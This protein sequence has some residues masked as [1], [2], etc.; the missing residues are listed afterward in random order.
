MTNFIY[1]LY[2][3][4]SKFNLL[5][6]NRITLNGA[7]SLRFLD[8]LWIHLNFI[9]MKIRN[10]LDL[11]FLYYFRIILALLFI[12]FLYSLLSLFLY[13]ITNYFLTQY[14]YKDLILFRDFKLA[15]ILRFMIFKITLNII[16]FLLLLLLEY[17]DLIIIYNRSIRQRY[18]LFI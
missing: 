9:I 11:W 5:F 1:N 7:I 6:F 17:I 12:F 4:F 14:V 10:S 13:H 8:L 18:L 16:L 2:L 15:V 3:F